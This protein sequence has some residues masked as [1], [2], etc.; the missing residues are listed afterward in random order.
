VGCTIECLDSTSFRV[1]PKGEGDPAVFAV[2]HEGQCPMW[3]NAFTKVGAT[4]VQA[5]ADQKAANNAKQI[6]N[7][8]AEIEKVRLSKM[9]VEEQ[10]G[11]LVKQLTVLTEEKLDIQTNIAVMKKQYE[12]QI[13][14]LERQIAGGPA[15]AAA[16]PAAGGK[17]AFAD[18]SDSDLDADELAWKNKASAAK[19]KVIA[20]DSD[21][22]LDE[23]EKKFQKSVT[24]GAK[25][26]S[27]IADA[28]SDD[29]S[30]GDE[31]LPSAA[32]NLRQ[33]QF[34]QAQG[35]VFAESDSDLDEEEIAFMKKTA[36][37]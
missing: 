10:I 26:S 29:E 14:A 22:D 30:S 36:K 24:G 1:V 12:D 31:Q 37:K 5:T 8:A 11:D 19:K 13:K 6:E 20:D 4:V 35:G 9:D 32:A 7:L 21:D 15:A 33:K 27:W 16:A 17:K 2:E 23:E 3:I 18:D 28:D 34:L 25:K